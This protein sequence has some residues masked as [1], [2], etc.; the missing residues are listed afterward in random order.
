MDREFASISGAWDYGELP[1]NVL[2][3]NDCWLE[4]RSSFE[5]FRSARQPGL[6]L[7]DRVRVYT[8]TTFI[9]EPSGIVTIGSDSVLV[10]AV[11]MCADGME[12]GE[13]VVIS[14]HVTIADSDFHPLDPEL[15]R[16]DAVANSPEGDRSLR[17]PLVARPV[18]GDYA[19][20]AHEV[21]IA[22]HC[23]AMPPDRF[24]GGAGAPRSG[25]SPSVPGSGSGRAPSCAARSG[26]ARGPWSA[27]PPWSSM[28]C[29]PLP[30]SWATR[31][32]S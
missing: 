31:H 1:P 21:V 5:R 10:G 30:S 23:I 25:P 6:V 29:R 27:R 28:M 3:G 8:W 20:I 19:L 12:V 2:I 11:F 4:R 22:D 16:L 24:V 15:R 18:V 14:Y 7:G 13:R 26:S 9:V 32:A 17:Q